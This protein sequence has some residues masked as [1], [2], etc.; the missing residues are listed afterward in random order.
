[1]YFFAQGQMAQEQVAQGQACLTAV[2]T[3]LVV[4]EQAAEQPPAAHEQASFH[5]IEQDFFSLLARLH[6]FRTFSEM[7]QNHTVN[8]IN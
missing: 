2:P 4:Q 5:E 8:V 6:V 1:M 7:I 3:D